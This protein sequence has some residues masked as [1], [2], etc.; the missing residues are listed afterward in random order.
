MLNVVITEG[1]L[2]AC[3]EDPINHI[4]QENN[5]VLLGAQSMENLIETPRNE[6]SAGFYNSRFQFPRVWIQSGNE[7]RRRISN[8]E[9]DKLNVCI[10][11]FF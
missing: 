8:Q 5:D 11:I 4:R 10:F 2:A 6:G 3:G 1:R 9:I 7:D